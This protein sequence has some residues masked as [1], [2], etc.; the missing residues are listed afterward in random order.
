MC[1]RGLHRH[2]AVEMGELSGMSWTMSDLA[3]TIWD[4]LGLDGNRD[5]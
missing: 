5:V 1:P 2:H 3:L 4:G